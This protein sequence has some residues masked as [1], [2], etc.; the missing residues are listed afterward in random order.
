MIVE[1]HFR[2]LQW[3]PHCKTGSAK[4]CAM[5][6]NKKKGFVIYFFTEKKKNLLFT[7]NFSC[8]HFENEVVTV[9]SF[10]GSSCTAYWSCQV[11]LN[12]MYINFKQC[13]LATSVS[14]QSSDYNSHGSSQLGQLPDVCDLLRKICTAQWLWSLTR[15]LGLGHSSPLMHICLHTWQLGSS[16]P[17]CSRR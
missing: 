15:Q 4:T 2:F 11:L 9:I 6:Q 17:S 16:S 3:C 1:L 13:L 7:S 8:S 5:W 12:N 10:F 14:R